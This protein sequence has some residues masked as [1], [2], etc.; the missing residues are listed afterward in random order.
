LLL[1]SLKRRFEPLNKYSGDC[2]PMQ[3]L[4]NPDRRQVYDIYGKEGLSAGLEVGSTLKS[5]DELRQEWE[6]FKAQQVPPELHTRSFG[7][8][9]PSFCMPG[10]RGNR[11]T[12]LTFLVYLHFIFCHESFHAHLCSNVCAPTGRSAALCHDTPLDHLMLSSCLLGM[13]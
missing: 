12:V 7:M 9:L 3:V 10:P 6:S 13:A 1:K 11:P 4:S 5:T 8:F 2:V